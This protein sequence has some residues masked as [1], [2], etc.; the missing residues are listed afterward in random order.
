[1]IRSIGGL[2]S[3]MSKHYLGISIELDS[4]RNLPVQLLIGSED[5]D[6]ITIRE[7]SPYWTNGANHAGTTRLERVESLYLQYQQLG[8][9]VQ[10][11]IIDG[12]KHEWLPLKTR[13]IAFFETQLRNLQ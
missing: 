3:E 1:M 2:A 5:S 4:L 9:D 10:L 7:N 6:D 11:E 12:C 13:T 8:S